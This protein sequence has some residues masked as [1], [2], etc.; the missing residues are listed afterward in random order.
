MFRILL[1]ALVAHVATAPVVAQDKKATELRWY[2]HSMFQLT[3]AAG[4]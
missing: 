4:T 3:T 1:V 2:G